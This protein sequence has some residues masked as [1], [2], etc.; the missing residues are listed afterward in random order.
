MSMLSQQVGAVLAAPIP[1]VIT[2]LPIGFAMWGAWQWRYKAVF[3]K[4]KEL[5]DLSRS[6]VDHW[7]NIAK[8]TAAEL[9]EKIEQLEQAEELTDQTK[10]QLDQMKQTTS[11]LNRQLNN[12]GQANLNV[13]AV[14][15][16]LSRGTVTLPSN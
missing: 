7:K 11:T 14:V 9:V 3:G 6:E 10:A 5:Y 16:A 8:R 13:P 1:F 15:E 2:L 4:Q 12:L